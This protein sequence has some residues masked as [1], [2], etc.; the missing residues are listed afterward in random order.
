MYLEYFWNSG[1]RDKIQGLDILGLRQLD[2]NLESA[3]VANITT[4]S[5]RARYL[6]LLPWI[7]AEF[8]EH[9]LER[10]AGKAV[11]NWDRLSEVLARIKFV[12]LAA[13]A[14][15]TDWGES[16]DTFGV[17]GSILWADQLEKFKANQKI[18]IPN[19]HGDDIYGTYI[20]PCRGFGLLTDSPASS[21][22]MPVAIGPR[23]QDLRKMRA[24]LADCGVIKALLFNGGT[25][26]TDHLAEFGYLFSVNGLLSA[27]GERERLVQ[28]MFKPFQDRADVVEAYDK[29]NATT[30]W[31]ARFINGEGVHPA[32]VIAASFQQVLMTDPAT[33]KPVDLAWMEYELRRR[34]HFGCELLLADVTDTLQNLTTGSVASVVER[35]MAVNGCSPAVREAIGFDR[36][37]S[38]KTLD[39]IIEGMPK[40]AFLNK[41]LHIQEGRD[42]EPGGNRAFYGL[43]LLL[44]SHYYTKRVRESGLL[45]DRNHYMERAFELIDVNG[46]KPLAHALRELTLHLAVEPHLSTTLRKMGQGQKCSLRFFPDGE[47]LRPTGVGVTPGFSGSRLGNVLGLLADVGLCN[48]LDGGRFNLTDEGR[49]WLLEGAA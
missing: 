43:A 49:K 44:S 11:I 28:W 13:S 2:Q 7:L 26:T 32:D 42:Q 8:Y 5:Y 34:V 29:F 9:E 41:R 22:G 12:I 16:G 31:A 6:T 33:V 39:E 21:H 35:W 37:T 19:S 14:T 47:A 38:D 1:E 27:E 20:M 40:T 30:R 46:S 48:R 45:G 3:W 36:P 10:G 17:L 24:A 23:G 4:I 25:L 15:G 18:E